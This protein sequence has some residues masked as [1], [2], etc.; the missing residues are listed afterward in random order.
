MCNA[1]AV[2]LKVHLISMKKNIRFHF[3]C[4]SQSYLFSPALLLLCEF[5]LPYSFA[6]ISAKT[7]LL[8]FLPSVLPIPQVFYTVQPSHLLLKPF[9]TPCCLLD[10]VQTLPGFYIAFFAHVSSL[11]A[12]HFTW[13]LSSTSFSSLNLPLT[14]LH[15]VASFLVSLANS[16]FSWAWTRYYF[17]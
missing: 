6:C 3:W 5:R 15:A 7:S 8:F 11:V 10:E 4:I 2:S 16:Y 13:H 17:F 12:Y 1:N 9:E 14:F